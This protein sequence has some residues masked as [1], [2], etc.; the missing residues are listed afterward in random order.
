MIFLVLSEKMIF[1]FPEKMILFFRQK[2]KEDLYQK[3]SWEYDIFFKCS[4]K[5]VFP[6]KIAL[7]YDL[8]YVLSEKILLCLPFFGWKMKD[9]LFQEIHGNTIFSVCTYKSYKYDI[10]LLPKNSKTVF[11]RENALKGD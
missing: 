10:I 2:M 4:E 8:F 5:M 9:N 6:K 3:N 7:E 1:L 11:S